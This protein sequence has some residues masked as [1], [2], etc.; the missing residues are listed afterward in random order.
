MSYRFAQEAT[1][2]RWAWFMDSPATSGAVAPSL[3]RV[4]VPGPACPSTR[5]ALD[6]A[7]SDDLAPPEGAHLESFSNLSGS[8]CVRL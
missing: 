7:K 5:S 6:A 2:Q 8:T 3:R 1:H 4:P